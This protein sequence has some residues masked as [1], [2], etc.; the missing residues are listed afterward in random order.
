MGIIRTAFMATTI[1]AFGAFAQAQADCPNPEG[2]NC[3][4]ATPG[5][6]GCANETCCV[7]VCEFD[8]A[9]CDLEWDQICA[10]TAADLCGSTCGG[11]GGGGGGTTGPCEP[12]PAVLGD[13]PVDTTASESNLDLT[14]YCDPGDFGDDVIY[15]TMYFTFVPEESDSYSMTTCNQANFDTRLAVLGEACDESTVL[16]CL[17]DTDGCDGFTTTISVDLVAGEEYTISVGGYSAADVGTGTLTITVGAPPDPCEGY[18]N[19]CD[20]PEIVA[21][22]GDY[23]FDTQCAYLAGDRNLDFTGF[24]DPGTFG[25]DL[26]YNNYFFE[27]TA[28]TSESYTFTT[29]NQAGF[30]TRLAVLADGCDPS[31][32]IVCLDDTDGCD[33]FTT[34]VEATLV[35]G[36][37]YSIAVGGYAVGTYGT[38]TLTISAGD[39]PDP[40]EGYTNDCSSPEVVGVGD[41]EFDTQCAYLLGGRNLDFTGVCDP[42]EFG[43]DLHYNNYF[44]AFTPGV[45]GTYEFTTCSQAAIDTRLSILADGC[46]PSSVIACLD[47]TE[48]CDGFT[49]T[50]IVDLDAGTE[51]V[52]AVGGYA[53]GTFGTGTLSIIGEDAPPADCDGDLNGDGQVDGSDLFILLGDWD[54]PGGDLNGDGVTDGADLN[55]LLGEWGDC[56]V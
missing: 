44:Y 20:A 49:Q 39:P 6:A 8:Q 43:D 17:D 13:N 31:S 1:G 48:G 4:E 22:V 16:V 15:N 14:G 28:P 24:C 35:E 40:C 30:D 54:G 41:Y 36:E 47:D 10:D 45:S 53:A 37:T 27:F 32:V 23:E 25:D 19:N 18:T 7:A 50:I 11:G 42:G 34:T 29:C 51:Y 5:I 33:G 38:G 46:D 21:A 56:P 55:Q 12:V 9:C 26:H 3:C 52:V 2:G